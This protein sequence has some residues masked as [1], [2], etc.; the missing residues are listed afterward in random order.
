MVLTPVFTQHCAP[1]TGFS[2]GTFIPVLLGHVFGGGGA[3]DTLGDGGVTATL[4]DGGVTA[5][6]RFFLRFVFAREQGRG[7]ADGVAGGEAAP[8][9][10]VE[11]VG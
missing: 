1:A 10:E 2:S 4:S 7:F 9:G 11:L 8:A 6:L 5:T 3:A